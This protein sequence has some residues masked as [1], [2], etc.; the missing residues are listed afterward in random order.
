MDERTE[1]DA[2]PVEA[3]LAL[4]A[5]GD[6]DELEAAWMEAVEA[7]ALAPEGAVMVLRAAAERPGNARAVAAH[8]ESLAWFLLSEWADRK[9][10]RA[11][12]DVAVA[13]ADCLPATDTLREQVADL[14]RRARAAFSSIDAL[15]K[16]TL[17]ASSVPLAEGVDW[18]ERALALPPGTFVRDPRRRSPGRVVGFDESRGGVEVSFGESGRAYDPASL[19]VLERLAPDD[20]RALAAFETERLTALAAEDPE[21]LAVL[22]LRAHG[23]R[24]SL[25]D[26]R[27]FLEPV[28]SSKEW[29]RWWKAARPVLK[30]AHE[31]EMTG[32]TRPELILRARPMAFED[33]VRRDYEALASTEE[34]ALFVLAHLSEPAVA[35]P[36]AEGAI[37]AYL[38]VRLE[39]EA[40]EADPAWALGLR[41]VLAPVRRR[42][43]DLGA[44]PPE[45][46]PPETPA[47]EVPEP[48]AVLDLLA[49]TGNDALAQSALEYVRDAAGDAWPEAFAAALPACSPNV[50]KW[51]ARQLA[52][53]GREDALRE[54]VSAVLARPVESAGALVWLWRS[55]CGEGGEAGLEISAD[56]RFTAAAGLLSAADELKREQTGSDEAAGRYLPDVQ[57]ALTAK[58]FATFRRVLQESTEGQVRGLRV[59]ASRNAGLT[60][61]ARL[62]LME[63]IREA[64]PALHAEKAVPPWEED[65]I[66]TTDEALQA[67]QEEFEQLVTVKMADNREAIGSAAGHGDLSENAEWTA[68]LEERDR[69]VERA[70]RMQEDLAKARVLKP[71]SAETD[72]VTVGSRV[73][74]RDLATGR[75]EQLIF[76]GPWDADPQRGIYYY[77]TP[78]G[79]AFMGKRVGE[80]A[81]MAT[82]SETR[83][84]EIVETGP[85]I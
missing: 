72:H 39:A 49:A 36:E 48:A 10:T 76:L 42:M 79:L 28:V 31:I 52:D 63:A 5:S 65:V 80:T 59:L 35:D 40:A 56:E 17:L 33:Q 34:R 46:S 27:A 60:D 57:R 44:A 61:L 84:W 75:T 82:R 45:S 9:G 13:A 68:A 64:H 21:R 81:E 11:A 54:A 16:T 70:N 25:Q 71:G 73:T 24:L 6:Y 47:A 41:A 7:D 20:Y 43:A 1:D 85:A 55:G 23:P 26:F 66:Y 22:L 69:L 19:D 77:R 18:T 74:A 37:L 67:R 29:S 78:L 50:A 62:R 2:S 53:A 32:G 8:L 30:R 3:L 4:A 51:A 38:A 83:R 15:T 58:E 14:Y 12:L